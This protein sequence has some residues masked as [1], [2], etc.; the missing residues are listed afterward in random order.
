MG[1]GADAPG[2]GATPTPAEQILAGQHHPGMADEGRFTHVSKPPLASLGAPSEPDTA[3]P[4]HRSPMPPPLPE[5]ASGIE[6]DQH[7]FILRTAIFEF[8]QDFGRL[9]AFEQARERARDEWRAATTAVEQAE[10]TLRAARVHSR[11]DLV[12]AYVN[13]QPTDAVV[14]ENLAQAELD[15]C[16]DRLRHIEEISSALRAETDSIS[17]GLD[18]HRHAIARAAGRVFSRSPQFIALV[19]RIYTAYA[20]LRDTRVAISELSRIVYIDDDITS[21]I[22][23]TQ[24]SDGSRR[25]D[26]TNDEALI[27]LWKDAATALLTDGDALLP[28]DSHRIS[29]DTN[30]TSNGNSTQ[31]VRGS[32]TPRQRARAARPSLPAAPGVRRK[33]AGGKTVGTSDRRAS[34]ARE[35]TPVGGSWP[36]K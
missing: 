4:V 8:A 31:P 5:P 22:D 28:G 16:R 15:E 19:E 6:E 24:P 23:N 14:T 34:L 12:T 7:R 13:N 21:L 1:Q 11:G 35:R 18:D 29:R 9:A 27:A 20:T 32:A 33:R 10:A 36:K 26:Y 3:K 2:I 25:R 17:D 30:G